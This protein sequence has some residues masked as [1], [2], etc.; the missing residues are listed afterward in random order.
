MKNKK[1][2]VKN[3]NY[4]YLAKEGV[5]GVFL[6]GFMS[7][8]AVCVTVACLIIMG[9]F[10]MIMLNLDHMVQELDQQNQVLVYVDD[11][12]NEAEAHSIGSQINLIENVFDQ[13]FV[14]KEQALESFVAE[15]NDPTMFAGL[16]ADT[17][18]HR[19]VVTLQSSEK[20]AET[21]EKL[22]ALEGVADVNAHLEVAEGF[23][24]VRNVLQFVS[25]AIIIILLVVSLF[26][27]ANTVKLALYDRKDEIGIMKMVGATNTFIR[28]P[29]IIEGSIIGLLSAAVAFFAEWGI[30]DLLTR[31]ISELD[32]LRLFSA[33]PFSDVLGTMVLAFVG[34]GLFVGIFGS[35]M[36]IRKFLDV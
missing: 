35:L 21:V 6:H 17:L 3:K 1:Y 29:F 2:Y 5:R 8:A 22:K 24:T 13:E 31:K 7:F 27:I 16:S 30:Y 4:G 34:A 15:Q 9:S 18:R 36:S 28:I 10:S 19:F 12:L 14:T 11:S 26:I 25:Y 33:I 23:G 20:M 32:T